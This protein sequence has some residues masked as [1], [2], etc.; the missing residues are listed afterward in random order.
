MGIIMGLFDKF[1]KNTDKNNEYSE[2]DCSKVLNDNDVDKYIKL[3][4][5]KWIYVLSPIFGGAEDRSNQILVTSGADK[6]K[7]LVDEELINFLKQGK[8]VK[9]L[10]MNFEY[11]KKS[12]VVSKI[13][14]SAIVDENDYN[15]VIEV[16]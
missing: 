7:Q 2:L 6:E 14:I 10:K 9:K 3:G 8:S 5:L 11:K 12:L 13:F 15:K 1:K 16:W 4:Q